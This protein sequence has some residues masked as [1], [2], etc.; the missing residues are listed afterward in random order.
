MDREDYRNKELVKRERAK[1]YLDKF[2]QGINPVDEAPIE[3]NSVI[4]NPKVRNCFQF[5]SDY[6]EEINR[7]EQ[8][9]LT[10]ARRV[11]PFDLTDEEKLHIP[12]VNDA[13]SVSEFTE[14]INSIVDQ[15]SMKPLKA[16]SI[17]AWLVEKGFLE[18]VV[19]N[20]FNKKLPTQAGLQI[21]ILTE[22]RFGIKNHTEYKAV[23][24]SKEAQQFIAD[25][26][27][28]I[29]VVNNTS[30]SKGDRKITEAKIPEMEELNVSKKFEHRD[31]NI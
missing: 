6:L 16:A 30:K 24:Y 20:G 29:I 2:L 23:L 21:G 11:Q 13:L 27:G 4:F 5:L 3:P 26:I 9:R 1:M 28:E 10:K 8:R 31:R 25:N 12:I 19:E 18:I 15:V 14:N 22:T 17:N 7:K